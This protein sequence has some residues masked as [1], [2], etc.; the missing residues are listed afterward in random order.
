VTV[1]RETSLPFLR[2][3]EERRPWPWRC[4]PESCGCFIPVGAQGQVGWGPGQP[5]LVGGSQPTGGVGTRWA[6]RSLPT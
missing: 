6:L 4:C 5:E 1:K 2:S 3:K